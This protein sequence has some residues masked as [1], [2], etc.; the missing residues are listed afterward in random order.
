[1]TVERPLR[2]KV[3]L[4]ASAQRRFAKTCAEVSEGPLIGVVEAVAERLGEGPHLDFNRFL[5]EAEAVAGKR[6]V[7]MTAKR[8]KLLMAGLGIKEPSAEPVIKKVSKIK[9]GADAES[10]AL[11]GNYHRTVGGKPAIVEF[12]PDTELR[13]T[14][15]VPFLEDGGIEAFFRREVLP[16][17]ADAWIDP[18][19][20]VIGYE[21]S[22]TRHFYKPQPLRTLQEIEADIRALEQ[23]TEG[24]LEDVLTGGR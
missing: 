9:P 4:S 20:T 7:R 6:G 21:I 23:E 15:Q 10:D 5:E 17:A 13:D 2:L 22:F 3:E 24:L 1:M 14:E 18:S 19:K 16:H 12:E 11:Y 8:Q